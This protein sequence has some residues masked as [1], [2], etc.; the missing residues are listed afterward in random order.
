[1]FEVGSGSGLWNLPKQAGRRAP[2]ERLLCPG[3]ASPSASQLLAFSPGKEQ[4]AG[5]SGSLGGWDSG[6]GVGSESR[7]QRNSQGWREVK[8]PLGLKNGLEEGAE[9]VHVISKGTAAVANGLLQLRTVYKLWMFQPLGRPGRRESGLL[10]ASP[11]TELCPEFPSHL[12]C[13][14]AQS[15]PVAAVGKTQAPCALAAPRRPS[16][17]LQVCSPSAVLIHPFSLALPLPGALPALSSAWGHFLFHLPGYP[18]DR[19]SVV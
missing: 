18:L 15:L 7:T 17:S 19:K 5:D 6:V 1:M 11:D 12:T 9:S 2:A 8:S 14:P 16:T 10:R 4:A 13:F 3:R